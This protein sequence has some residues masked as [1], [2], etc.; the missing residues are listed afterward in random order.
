LGLG[1]EPVDAAHGWS[2]AFDDLRF[3]MMHEVEHRLDEGTTT[4]TDQRDA[5]PVGLVGTGGMP[6]R[7]VE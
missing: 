7:T 4:E 3:E 5:L 2:G 1:I 6:D